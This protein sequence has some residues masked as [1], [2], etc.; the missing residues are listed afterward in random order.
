MNVKVLDV[1]KRKNSNYYHHMRDMMMMT[2]V[3]K[4]AGIM[5]LRPFEMVTVR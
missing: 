4:S 2:S 3:L 1:L 5:V